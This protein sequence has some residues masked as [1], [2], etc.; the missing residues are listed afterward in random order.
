MTN[1]LNI[2]VTA[3][4][5][6]IKSVTKINQDIMKIEG[7]IKKLKLQATL[8]KGKSTAEIQKQIKALNEQKRNLYV[9]LKL[10]K[11]D[12]KSQY[13]QAIASIQ[14]QPLNVD[15]NTATAQNQ[16]SGLTNSVRATTSET[17]TLASSLKKALTNSGLVIS[18]Q[19]A[20]QL[21]RKAAQEATAAVKEYDD[22]SKNLQIITG[23][24]KE[25]VREMMSDLA[26]KS[27]DYKVDISDLE[28]AQE[29]LLR[30]GKSVED[31]NYLMKDTVMLA[32]T[33]FM[34]TDDAAES[35]V[36]I[37]NAYKYEADEMENVISKFL[38][39]DTASNTVAGKLSSAIAKTASNAQ[40]AGVSIDELGGYISQLKNTTGKSENEIAT[41][42]NSMFSRVGNV[43]LG[44]YEIELEDGTSEDITQSLNDTERMLK[45][46]GIQLRSSKG[47]FKDVDDILQEV[48]E[49]WKDFNSVEKNSI[50]KTFAGTMHRNTFISLV[51]NYDKA[52]QLAEVSVNSAGTATEKYEAYMES[53]EAKS[54]A[55]STSIKELWND[56][57]P[58]NLAG[59]MTD[60]TT[61]VVQFI[62]KYEIL[63]TA[64]KSAAFYALAKG[65]IATKNS[66]TGMV[67]DIKNVSTAMNLA[68]QSGTMTMERMNGLAVAVKG[69]TDKQLM[70]VLSSSNLSEAQMIEL[71]RLNGVT[72]AEA[73]QK[74]ATLGIVQANT[75]ATASTFSLSG[76]FKALWATIAANPIG[77]IITAFS[78][79]STAVAGY[80]QHQQELIE[81]AKESADKLKTQAKEM[82]DFVSHYESIID[83]EKTETEKVAELNEWKQTLADTYGITKDKLADLNLERE[84][85]IKLLEEEIKLAK[86]KQQRDWL[87][88]NKKA[89]NKAK[90]KLEYNQSFNNDGY[91]YADGFDYWTGKDNSISDEIKNLFDRV[92][93]IDDLT[94]DFKI[95]TSNAIE[96]YER[97][98]S[99]ATQIRNISLKRDLTESEQLLFDDIS[100]QV[101]YLRN[102][103]KDN[104][105]LVDVYNQSIASQAIINLEDYK[106]TDES[107]K[108]L[109]KENYLA[110]R[111][112]LLAT[113][114]GDKQ[115]E[116]ELLALAEKQFPDYAEYFKNLDLAKSMFGVSG[117]INN[118]FDAGKKKFLEE[119]SDEDLKIAVNY[120]PDLF[121]DGLDGASKKI[122]EFKADPKNSIAPSFDYSTYSEQVDT[123]VKN[124]DKVQ[125]AIDKLNEGK[126]IDGKD[127]TELANTF[128][129]YSSE[130][131]S[132][133]D[134]TEKLKAVLKDIKSD[135]PKSLINTLTNLKDL[136]EQDQEAVN[137]LIT[138][139]SK[140]GGASA[141]YSDMLAELETR[142]SM[143]ST[144]YKEMHDDG[145]LSIATYQKLAESG[146]DYSDAISIVNG[147]ITANIQSLKELT[148]EKYQNEIATL[149][150]KKAEIGWNIA[151]NPEKYSEYAEQIRV[152]NEELA[153]LEGITNLYDA[154]DYTTTAKKDKDEKPERVLA[155]E[156][157]LAKREHEINMGLR[158]EDDAYYDWLLS[159]AHTA[160]DGLK[161]YQD[162]LWK[163]EE[164]VYKWRKDKEQELFDEKIENMKTLADK[165]LDSN[166]VFG[167]LTRFEYARNQIT[168][169]ISEIQKRIN[170]IQ[171]GRLAGN[172]DNI[173]A[174]NDELTDLRKTL[175]DINKDELEYELDNETSYW[176]DLK[177]KQEDI[178]DKEID[179]LEKVKDA[180][181]KKNEEEEKATDLAEKQLALEKAK[182]ELE[183]ARQNRS[184][185][186]VTKQGTFYTADQSAIDEAEKNVKDA[187]KDIADAKKDDVTDKISEQIDVLKEQK[188][189]T[190][191]YYDT[192]I[193]LLEDSQ[194]DPL[195]AEANRDLWGKILATENGQNAIAS[196]DQDQVN[197]LIENG[198]LAF[199]DGKYSLNNPDAEVP[200]DSQTITKSDITDVLT[201]VFGKKEGYTPE[202]IASIAEKFEEKTHLLYDGFTPS[203]VVNKATENVSKT[204]N[205]SQVINKVQN[206]NTTYHIDKIEVG[207]SGNDFEGLLA[208]TLDSISQQIIIDGNKALHG[209]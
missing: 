200:K 105:D 86:V 205:N 43:K 67:T 80:K 135:T 46:V 145:V 128:P 117:N 171:E 120:I 97:L 10:R 167:D 66:F 68:T 6:K 21:V 77:L 160:Y 119:L 183:K 76:A 114:E 153:N 207:Y 3:G 107:Y 64:I 112:G 96:E 181:S 62:D 125:S 122:Q 154:F 151:A 168:S 95:N 192:I 40:M 162:E 164:T 127:I 18:S 202:K 149:R 187:E 13:K 198:F 126:G 81:Q 110:W 133:S 132:A 118:G 11:K 148:K 75:T 60:A 32:K 100:S 23:Q 91:T 27:L 69:L 208:D 186:L 190:Q 165:A 52:M 58:N 108:N 175:A 24:S 152:V 78:L 12:L 89:I 111:D 94:V 131:L 93:K 191:N 195:Q 35:L 138:I 163:H 179:K 56:L 159:A 113:A 55:L 197:K 5:D 42:L 170:D 123:V 157:E 33:G 15:V 65:V 182:L 136:S 98:D 63:Q 147:K 71:L 139:L 184:V 172:A 129:E 8:D 201:T 74:L 169:A 141:S 178:Y 92:E 173:K 29:T 155:F 22:M 41:A 50:A 189:N 31:V 150:L 116:D 17:V 176:E 124:L 143:L 26:D 48:S 51:E 39:L 146:I 85:G 79:A 199:N 158:E 193:K 88:D 36:T 174:L 142:E 106:I 140:F 47:E 14:A 209:R 203:D 188:E 87:E 49:H 196:A 204:I 103:L 25:S 166:T 45:N 104:A 206:M 16:M 102:F 134:N 34:D 1:N 137:G 161:D 61:S 130:I 70:L 9:D 177:S 99:I 20:L 194:N 109:G 53:L 121:A 44:K 90:N 156:E 83:S 72:E 37:A 38:A 7:Q 84:E 2:S 144:A 30:T 19:T 101:N 59:D 82:D 57:V 4:L 180:I 73:R 28:K 115:L 54:A 185:M